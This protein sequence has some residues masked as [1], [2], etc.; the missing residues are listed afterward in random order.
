[1][2]L[3]SKSILESWYKTHKY[4]DIHIILP[5]QRHFNF[6]NAR[7]NVGKSYSTQKFL[8]TEALEKGKQFILIVRTQKEKKEGVLAQAF[9]KVLNN[10]FEGYEFNFK[11]DILTCNGKT[12]GFCYALTESNTFKKYSFPNVYY[13]YFEEYMIEEDKG[14][15]YVGGWKEPDILLNMYHTADR[16]ED[17]ITCFFLGN[18]TS[19]YNPYHLHSAFKIPQVES[20]EIWYSENV[21]FHD[22]YPSPLL[23]ADESN[24][25]F[26]KMIR[27][28]DYNEY[29]SEGNY[30]D[31]NFNFIEKRPANTHHLAN[32]TNNS[33][34]FGLWSSSIT[35]NAYISDK[36]DP[37][38]KKWLALS[39][40]DHTDGRIYAFNKSNLILSWVGEKFKKGEMRFESMEIKKKFEDVLIKCM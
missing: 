15:R 2:G 10:E 31:D 34:T 12:L 27:G 3:A 30:Y 17:R 32:I 28:T 35:G 6:I 23:K 20:G 29:A 37:S 16:E 11:S 39:K 38:S 8:I 21:L 14:Q 40:D 13:F 33:F 4:W 36:F 22:A 18:N 5:F 26:M 1:M 19:F 24:S 9:E 7:R 25:M